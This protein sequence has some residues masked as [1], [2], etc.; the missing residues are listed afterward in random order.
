M[1]NTG[2]GSQVLTMVML[3]RLCSIKQSPRELQGTV[4]ELRTRLHHK[5]LLAT[6]MPEAVGIKAGLPAW[7]RKHLLDAV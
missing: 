2:C 3:R 7:H 5:M 6:E 4:S 1:K